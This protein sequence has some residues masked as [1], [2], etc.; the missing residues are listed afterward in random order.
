MMD[1]IL[2]AAYR[3]SERVTRWLHPWCRF[4]C[5][6]LNL[7]L[8]THGVMPESGLLLCNHLS[9]LDIIAL[10]A[11]RPAV[12]WRNAM[13]VA[14]RSLASWHAPPEPFLW[15]AILEPRRRRQ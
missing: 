13:C 15:N 5:R 2:W 10:S 1:E 3:H 9:Y 11:L 14:G 8:K 6:V 4:A 7:R 12:L